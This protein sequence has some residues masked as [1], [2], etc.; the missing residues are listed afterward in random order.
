MSGM[1]GEPF[2]HHGITVGPSLPEAQLQLGSHGLYVATLQSWLR[3]LAEVTSIGAF[4][5]DP[6][7]P[8]GVALFGAATRSAVLAVQEHAGYPQ[9]GA[10]NEAVWTYVQEQLVRPTLAPLRGVLPP[11]PLDRIPEFPERGSEGYEATLRAGLAI[12]GFQISSEGHEELDR[13]VATFQRLARAQP[14][15]LTP[16][17]TAGHFADQRFWRRLWKTYRCTWGRFFG[18]PWLGIIIDEGPERWGTHSLIANL[19][20]VGRAY[21]QSAESAEE[22]T[23]ML[24]SPIH[25]RAIADRLGYR[26]EKEISHPGE[27]PTLT[28]KTPQ[29]KALA[30]KWVRAYEAASAGFAVVG[31]DD[32]KREYQAGSA[33][34]NGRLQMRV[35]RSRKISNTDI[36]QVRESI[37][38]AYDFLRLQWLFDFSGLDGDDLA[39]HRANVYTGAY[40]PSA[41]ASSIPRA[42]LSVVNGAVE[43]DRA[44]ALLVMRGGVL[45]RIIV[46]DQHGLHREINGIP[47]V[48]E[49]ARALGVELIRVEMDGL[50]SD[51]SY[52]ASVEHLVDG[53]LRTQTWTF[54]TL[55]ASTPRKGFAFIAASCYSDFGIRKDDGSLLDGVPAGSRY[56]HALDFWIAQ[57]PFFSPS[58]KILM[59]DNIYLDVAPDYLH[60]GNMIDPVA[61]TMGRYIR[62]WMTSNYRDVLKTLPTF[63]IPD[64]HEYW[65][66]F[67]RYQPHLRRT[68]IGNASAYASAARIALRA[69]QGAF[70]PFAR[71][72]TTHEP[73]DVKEFTYQWQ[74]E[75]QDSCPVSFFFFDSTST[76]K[77]GFFRL[78]PER[79]AN[80]EL[81]DQLCDWAKQLTSPGVLVIGQPLMLPRSYS[82]TLGSVGDYHPSAFPEDFRRIME[83]LSSAPWD[84][85]VLSGDVHWSRLIEADL[86]FYAKELFQ[87]ELATR[88]RVYAR[89]RPRMAEIISS[90]AQ[91]LPTK[92][93]IA[94][95]SFGEEGFD[96]PQEIYATAPWA[97]NAEEYVPEAGP[98]VRATTYESPFVAVRCQPIAAQAL[99]LDLTFVSKSGAS[100]SLVQQADTT[101]PAGSVL[102]LQPN[103]WVSVNAF[104]NEL[105][106]DYVAGA[107]TPDNGSVRPFYPYGSYG[108]D[109]TGILPPRTT[110]AQFVRWLSQGERLFVK[111]VLFQAGKVYRGADIEPAYQCVEVSTSDPREEGTAYGSFLEATYFVWAIYNGKRFLDPAGHHRNSVVLR[112]RLPWFEAGDRFK[113]SFAGASLWDKDDISNPS[114]KS[115]YE[116]G[117]VAHGPQPQSSLRTVAKDELGT[118][119]RVAFQAEQIVAVGP[120]GPRGGAQLLEVELDGDGASGQR[121]GLYWSVVDGVDRVERIARRDGAD[122]AALLAHW[123]VEAVGEWLRRSSAQFPNQYWAA[124]R[125][126]ALL[127]RPE[128]LRSG[129]AHITNVAREY[130]FIYLWSRY[131]KASFAEFVANLYEYHRYVLDEKFASRDDGLKERGLGKELRV[132][133]RRIYP[134]TELRDQPLD[135]LCMEAVRL[136]IN[137]S[138]T[139][140]SQW[141]GLIESTLG[142]TVVWDNE[143]NLGLLPS[144]VEGQR[145]VLLFGSF[146]IG[147]KVY[148]SISLRS[149]IAL[150]EE[151][152]FVRFSF[153][154]N[155]EGQVQLAHLATPAFVA[156]VSGVITWQPSITTGPAAHGDTIRA[157]E[158]LTPGGYVASP[159]RRYGLS[160][161][162]DGNLV[163]SKHLPDGSAPPL[164]DSR[165]GGRRVDVCILQQDGNLELFDPYGKLVWS[166]STQ[167]HPGSRLVVRDDGNVVILSANDAVVWSTGTQETV[168]HW[169]ALVPLTQAVTY[170]RDVQFEAMDALFA[171]GRLNVGL[172]PTEDLSGDP[173]L[174]AL[175]DLDV[176]ACT[177]SGLTAQQRTLFGNRNGMGPRDLVIYIV[178]SL[179]GANPALVGCAAHPAGRPGLAIKHYDSAG[180]WMTAHEIGHVLGLGHK[181]DPRSLMFDDADWIELPPDLSPSEFATMR[182]KLLTVFP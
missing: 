141:A 37:S 79:L 108:D 74:L 10:V 115:R 174:A 42:A 155:H 177:D 72:G 94:T 133:N 163:L 97:K 149:N 173:A 140:N 7:G 29:E 126:F 48:V 105:W 179:R 167:G 121:I 53:Q 111:R 89:Y 85:A 176:G 69:F 146:E 24:A 15:G 28:F 60:A 160:L 83:A 91:R 152:Q 57:S 66:D 16:S 13:A 104:S 106:R 181:S 158:I 161:Q 61:E 180:A 20:S 46:T 50:I 99:R 156:M 56:S 123:R 145:E 26:S 138:D 172:G 159:N 80:P 34:H 12:F 131:Q 170:F 143:L 100:L 171:S 112:K 73:D 5:P 14:L 43:K 132:G 38:R 58:F 1:I 178:R 45:G 95:G 109:E 84:I 32:V 51:R 36:T 65:N 77:Y 166:S 19:Y 151:G 40:L 128:S 168:I 22:L 71:Q 113:V 157:G 86:N 93:S 169:K 9:T 135:T 6:V 49:E 64:D 142:G 125:L 67:P 68:L 103:E 87:T 139:T 31:D 35:G 41:W 81:I 116:F 150:E 27:E 8:D 134:P 75:G 30:A 137:L 101:A 25:V 144:Y 107:S 63:G 122:R 98:R 82:A 76:R 110:G 127:D 130:L 54:R 78:F 52:V 88:Q 17:F 119:V 39:L 92:G 18:A 23:R 120:G 118:V 90:S 44:R 21:L 164:W 136:A 11:T 165:T 33:V 114:P 47:T 153:W 55:P 148:S 129:T 2:E 96:S 102:W 117:E 124:D 3:L 162:G 62:Y 147:G 70:T 154:P 4:Y 175:A 182:A 59:G